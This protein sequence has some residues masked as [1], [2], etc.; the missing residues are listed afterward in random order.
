MQLIFLLRDALQVTTTLQN[1]KQGSY[2]I[3]PT[4]S[5]MY[6]QRK[7]PLNTELETTVTFVNRDGKTGNYV[8]TAPA[9]QLH[10]DCTI[11]LY[12]CRTII[13]RHMML[14]LHTTPILFFDYSTPVTEPIQN[15]IIRHRLQRKIQLLQKRRSKTYHL[16]FG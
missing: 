15:Y 14:V 8:N 9:K 4:R 10:C 2:S 12:N 5:A 6:L 13:L 11:L 1:T 3:D 7:L 16:L